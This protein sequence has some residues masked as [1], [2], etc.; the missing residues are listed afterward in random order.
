MLK[1]MTTNLYAVIKLTN[2]FQLISENTDTIPP[3]Q[4]CIGLHWFSVGQS[5]GRWKGSCPTGA[6]GLPPCTDNTGSNELVQSL[7]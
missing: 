7:Y 3:S 4:H 6:S 2:I 1:Q 5:L